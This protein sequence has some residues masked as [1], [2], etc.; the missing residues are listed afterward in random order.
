MQEPESG[1]PLI[2]VTGDPANIKIL[3]VRTGKLVKVRNND[4]PVYA[5]VTWLTSGQTLIGHG[6][7]S[8]PA[9][10]RCLAC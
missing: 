8:V 2:C 10:S 5:G 3:N 1:D 7:V 4:A 9:A 6:G